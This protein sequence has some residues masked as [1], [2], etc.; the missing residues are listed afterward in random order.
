MKIKQLFHT[1]KYLKPIQL[2]YRIYYI[3]RG[4]HRKLLPKTYSSYKKDRTLIFLH[5]PSLTNT[6]SYNDGNFNFL[7]ISKQFSNTIDWNFN[8]YG[9]LWT[10]NLNYFDFLQQETISKVQAIELIYS[11]IEQKDKL[12]DG[13]EPYPISLRGI[14]WV[15]FLTQN[16]VQDNQIDT[17]LYVHYQ[18]LNDH[19][20]YHLLGNH[21]LEN[22]FSLL[23]GAFYFQDEKLHASGQKI[24]IQELE[25]QIL[26]D[27]AHFE[28]SPM[29]HQIL[30]HRLLDCINLYTSNPTLFTNQDKVLTK[31]IENASR[32]LSWLNT[33]TYK[34]GDIPMVNDAA[35]GI[36][37][38]TTDLIKYADR[39]GIITINKPLST[40]GYRKVNNEHYELLIDVGSIGPDYIPGHAHSD[41]F[42]FELYVQGVPFIVDTGT[43]TY[44][45]NTKRHSERITKAHNT[46][47]IG[48]I[49]QSDVWGG[50]RVGKRAKI[51][52]L[53]ENN[54]SIKAKHD[55]YKSIGCQHQR[56]FKFDKKFIT[57]EDQLI[58]SKE[59]NGKAYLHFH[60][61]VSITTDLDKI[62]LCNSSIFV[63]IKLS[64]GY[65][66]EEYEWAAGFNIYRNAKM[67]IISFR[68]ELTTTI[69]IQ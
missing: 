52:A 55:G 46:V 18:Q 37:A 22:G 61:D 23:F 57:I 36:A 33:I 34:N 54:H 30:L 1:L 9:K 49:E 28:L 16:K 27:G 35:W 15:K 65:T 62:T 51:I 45:K 53:E 7:N 6:N 17:L 69:S 5:Y 40:S 68:T 20:E 4:H 43:S 42:N 21:L 3:L 67:L 38:S 39:L 56:T 60:P 2:G 10:Y 58:S 14:N 41:T 31:L 63:T 59:T 11:Y 48:S 29:Y 32:M 19:L 13:T 26:T 66:I 12:K 64:C 24:V 44:E 50:F 47:Q 8:E 25:E